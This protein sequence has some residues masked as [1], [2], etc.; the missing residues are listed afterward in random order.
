MLIPV[1]T[2]GTAAAR[3]SP[4][5]ALRQ[6]PIEVWA[7]A[8]LTALAAVLRF[9][10]LTDQSFWVD[11]ATTAHEMRLS[12]GAMLHSVHLNE[13]TPP[14]YFVVAWLW[15]KLFGT[16][17]AGLR[18][19]SAVLGIGIVPITY[20]CGRE[21]VS[22]RA[23]LL[24]AAFAAISPFMIWYSQ[25][26]RAYMLFAFLCGA[27][28]L[29]W[30][31]VR[32]DPSRRN[33]SL[34]ALFSALAV[35]T[36][37]FAGFLVAPE[38]LWL[39]ARHRQRITLIAVGAVATVQATVVPLAAGDTNHPLNWINAFPLS[40]RIKQV[41]VDFGLSSLYQS[42]LVTS[43][44]LGAAL[45]GAIVIALF[46]LG[47]GHRAARRGAGLTAALA[48]AVILV[49][50]LLAVAGRDYLVPRN[51][52]P[53]WIPLAIV[54]AAACTLPRARLAG[55]A[56]AALVLGGFVYAGIRIDHDSAYQRPNWRGVAAALGPA[57]GSR[58]VVAYDG[59]FAAQPLAIYL[60]RVPWSF[61]GETGGNP[62]TVSEVDVI[63]NV[64]QASPRVLPSGAR[65][66][67]SRTVD[68][69]L[70]DRFALDPAWTATP[71]AIGARAGSLLGPPSGVPAVLLQGAP[72]RG[73]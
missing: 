5:E 13:T 6:V 69:F 51:L 72:G 10:T 16:G 64:Y 37:F 48:S 2:D 44:L 58:A 71:A 61:S 21:L 15:S 25:E 63:G 36:H 62:V 18:S 70:V 40:I 43:G 42:S 28:L 8:G 60:P 67:S 26:A 7:L 56:L 32:R 23:G 20:L 11:E 46:M 41:P 30:A 73:L 29:Y 1:R 31:R 19:L 14:L 27:S 34:W 24:A 33:L 66:I 68:G 39:L 50:L 49:P 38:A 59:G 22:R 57:S 47:G 3:S 45:L 65:R 12:F 52:T 17:E 9:A 35:L 4:A 54:L 53:A 55:A